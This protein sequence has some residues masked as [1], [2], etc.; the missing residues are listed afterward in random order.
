M[1]T[2]APALQSL[3]RH[4]G[5]RAANGV[6]PTGVEGVTFFWNEDPIPRA[7][8]LYESGLVI[9]GQGCKIGY[10]GGRRIEYGQDVCLVLGIP[11]P[12][13]CEV[14]AS[15]EEPTM[16]LRVDIDP[17]VLHG[18]MARLGN[19]LASVGGD[20]GKACFGVEPMKL[21]GPPLDTTVRLVES[22]QDPL[23][24]VV[25]APS[26]VEELIYRVLRAHEGRVLATLTQHQSSYAS[27]ARALERMHRDYPNSLSVADL[28]QESAMSVSTFHRTFKEVTGETPLR[29]LKKLRLLKAKS[30]LVFDG[31]R[32]D[33]AA[34]S[35]GY[36][37]TSQFSREFKRYFQVPPSQAQ[38]LPY[39][40]VPMP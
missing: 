40:A 33:E 10:L 15:P 22:L 28:A 34:F 19:K 8:L 39:S 38:T 27:I 13:E 18:L 32:V 36:A 1:S 12:F 14:I 23:D 3:R 11:V 4:L 24:Q 26:A 29:Y 20:K 30:H 35:V 37:S 25:V 5:G 7:P 16:G 9:V 31:L 21:E 6:A 17:V 2:L